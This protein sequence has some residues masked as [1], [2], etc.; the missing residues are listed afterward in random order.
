MDSFSKDRTVEVA[1]ALGARVF[2]EE[3]KGFGPQKASAVAKASHDWI[4]S[5]D[6]DEAVSPELQQDIATRHLR[7]VFHTTTGSGLSK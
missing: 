5:L 3:W 2:K 4:L 6:A 1:G 7:Q